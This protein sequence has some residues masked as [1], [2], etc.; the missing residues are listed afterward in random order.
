MEN[1]IVRIHRRDPDDSDRVTGILESVEQETHRLFHSLDDLR[2]M[3]DAPAAANMQTTG[4]D[5]TPDTQC[6][7]IDSTA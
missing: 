4:T 5:S 1:F 2:S 6:I 7:F 3:L